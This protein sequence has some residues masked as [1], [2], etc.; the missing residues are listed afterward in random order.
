LA[1]ESPVKITTEPSAI[2]SGSDAAGNKGASS[3]AK[4]KELAALEAGFD[5]YYSEG[6]RM[7]TVY[8][9]EGADA[10]NRS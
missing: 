7:T 5:W 4:L 1:G 9:A 3:A 2:K 10:G 6:K 8:K